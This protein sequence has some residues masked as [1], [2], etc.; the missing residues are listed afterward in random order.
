MYPKALLISL[1][2]GALSVNALTF[3]RES[4]GTTL[5][6]DSW[7]PWL[8]RT[9]YNPVGSSYIPAG[10]SYDSPGTSSKTPGT[11]IAGGMCDHVLENLPVMTRRTVLPSYVLYNPEVGFPA[12]DLELGPGRFETETAH[13]LRRRARSR[14]PRTT[15]Y[16]KAFG[17]KYP[18]APS[19]R[20]FDP[21]TSL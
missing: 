8:Q 2:G 11:C 1:L 21:S 3:A 13:T 7:S 19:M 6:Q 9:G 12:Q 10:S 18:R 17:F 16:R 5:S 20:P 15:G 14:E 4:Q